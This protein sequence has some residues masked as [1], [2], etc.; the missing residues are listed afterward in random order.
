MIN[1]R[2]KKNSRLDF[3]I[4]KNI[5]SKSKRSQQL[6]GLPFSVLFSII[7][8][9]FFI[10]IAFIAIRHFLGLRDCTQI[11]LF[12][13]D[14]QTDVDRAWGSQSSSF[15]F[16]GSLPSNLDYV[17]FANLSNSFKGGNIE[18]KVYSDISI[19]QY[20]DA[21]LFFYPRENACDMPYHKIKH[22]NV[23]RIIGLKNPYC[24]EIKNGNV[25]IDIEKEFGEGLVGLS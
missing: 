3:V 11:G 10:V 21:N 8:I 22:I 23:K 15:E 5:L 9:I 17:C 12:I 2:G 19:Y 24:I 14:L 7:L 18:S 1:K 16:S 25:V 20:A 4:R 13:E 6:F